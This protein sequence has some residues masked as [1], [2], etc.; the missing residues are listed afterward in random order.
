MISYVR[1]PGSMWHR[2][3]AE[4]VPFCAALIVGWAAVMVAGVPVGLGIGLAAWLFASLL[5]RAIRTV[6]VLYALYRLALVGHVLFWSWQGIAST[7]EVRVP[8]AGWSQSSAWTKALPFEAGFGAAPFEL[9]ARTTLAGWGSRPRRIALPPFAGFGVLGARCQR[10]MAERE[11][12]EAGP[13]RPLF[14][15]ADPTLPAEKLGARAL[16]LR[17][18]GERAP[19]GIV[20][21]DLVTS[22]TR[23]WEAILRMVADLGFRPEGLLVVASHT[24]SGPGGYTGL[25]LSALAGTDHYDPLV[26]AAIRD[27]AVAALRT[28]YTEA[29]PARI[30]VLQATDDGPTPL[31]RLRGS[32]ATDGTLDERV[33]A[34]RLSGRE[35]GAPIGVL[36]QYAVHPTLVRRRHQAFSRDIVGALEE[37]LS[38]VLPGNPPVLYVNGALGDVAPGRRHGSGTEAATL[39]ASEFAA[40]IGPQWSAPGDGI[41]G[42][43]LQVA[44]VRRHVPLPQAYLV[45]GLGKRNAVLDAVSRPWGEGGAAALAADVL[46]LPLN[47]LL[48][49]F[50]LTEI[51]LGFSWH[52]AAGVCIQ[53]GSDR[54]PDAVDVGVW[55]LG[56][57]A[58]PGTRTASAGRCTLLWQPGEATTA[59][60]L[61]WRERAQADG[62]GPVFLT[63]LTNGSMAYLT[64]EAEYR[65]GGYEAVATLYGPRTG[66]LIGAALGAA[67]DEAGRLRWR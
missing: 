11:D 60:G 6:P 27:A 23:L 36:V 8:D 9:P 65:R 43:H 62:G 18:V 46:A 57:G 42:D 16:V 31:A 26:F 15:S 4:F 3:A 28:A 52:G 24:H 55:E 17:P 41:Q 50:T 7:R 67:A 44:A 19:V 12:D 58:A 21:L 38:A 63:G 54:A 40:R 14:Q 56:I 64:T 2:L 25:T 34:L 13:R 1:G 45:E 37:E 33:H 49:S 10:W 53:L 35:D 51:R 5:I 29:R 39:L 32:G 66:H 22:G 48:W 47:A 20:R 59:L 61:A 30:E